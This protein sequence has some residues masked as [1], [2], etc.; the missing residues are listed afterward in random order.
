MSTTF[1]LPNSNP[2]SS[3]F[4]LTWRTTYGSAKKIPAVAVKGHASRKITQNR[5]CATEHHPRTLHRLEVFSSCNIQIVL[6]IV[7]KNYASEV[8]LIV[9]NHF[10]KRLLAQLSNRIKLAKSSI[11]VLFEDRIDFQ[12]RC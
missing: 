7:P 9:R 1:V 3:L 2:K 11:L 6:Y 8:A 10:T 5:H 4:L 12:M